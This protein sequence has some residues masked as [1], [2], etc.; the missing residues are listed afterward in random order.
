MSGSPEK[1]RSIDPRLLELLVCPLTRGSLRF[2]AA[3]LELVSDKARL[4]YPVRDG[5]PILLAEEARPIEDTP[6]ISRPR[7]RR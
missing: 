4:A 5:I 1:P 7:S 3:A 6:S 2:D